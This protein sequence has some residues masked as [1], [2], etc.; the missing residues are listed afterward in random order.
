MLNEQINQIE[1]E[2]DK[3]A[4]P[5]KQSNHSAVGVGWFY[6]EDPDKAS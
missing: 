1:A 5:V 2:I 3:D 4:A 6:W